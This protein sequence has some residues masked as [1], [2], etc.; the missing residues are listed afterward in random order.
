[1]KLAV[2]ITGA[3]GHLYAVGLLKMLI[4]HQD[5]EQI[6]MVISSAGERVFSH[7][8]GCTL[9]LWID[10]LEDSSKV[11][12]HH[13]N[14]IGASIA[15]GSSGMDGYIIVPCSMGTLGAIANGQSINL[16]HRM[17]DVAL[18]ER[19]LLILV[20]RETP[21]RTQHLKNMTSLSEESAI[22]MPAAPG[23]YGH[24]QTIEDLVDFI[25][26]RIL[27]HLGLT[28]LGKSWDGKVDE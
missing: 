16:I 14:N 21:F 6:H 20:P 1:M 26:Y 27:S 23:F 4:S 2:G 10:K 11:F 18:K 17:A 15:S 24:P 9:A 13:C 3:S 12:L 25:G 22:I 7:E 28:H 8:M 5:V 19:R